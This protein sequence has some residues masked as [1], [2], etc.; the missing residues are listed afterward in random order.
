MEQI[1]KELTSGALV[2]GG[3]EGS[4]ITVKGSSSD[5]ADN[6]KENEVFVE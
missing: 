6:P 4:L 5:G 2:I 1:T 3:N